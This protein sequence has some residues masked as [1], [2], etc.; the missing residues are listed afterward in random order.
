M[1]TCARILFLVRGVG[2]GVRTNPPFKLGF[3]KIATT[4]CWFNNK[5]C[6]LLKAQSHQASMVSP[7]WHN[8]N[9]SNLLEYTCVMIST[10][11]AH[12]NGAGWLVKRY[13][14]VFSRVGKGGARGASGPSNIYRG[15]PDMVIL[16]K[17]L[18]L[19]NK[20]KDVYGKDIS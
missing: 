18:V 3:Q 13:K 7:C 20:F 14:H 8:S 6:N 2:R 11:D 5:P 9:R 15:G 19:I 16:I 4:Y 10:C 1:F 17:N 12:Q